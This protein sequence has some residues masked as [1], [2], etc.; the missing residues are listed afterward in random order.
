M[1]GSSCPEY[2]RRFRAPE[3]LFSMGT[4]RIPNHHHQYNVGEKSSFLTTAF[5]WRVIVLTREFYGCVAIVAG[6]YGVI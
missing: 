4:S 3:R 5:P 1:A 2:E 6:G